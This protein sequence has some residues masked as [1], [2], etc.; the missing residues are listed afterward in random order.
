MFSNFSANPLRGLPNNTASQKRTVFALRNFLNRTGRSYSRNTLPPKYK[1]F[2]VQQFFTR[3]P[4]RFPHKQHLPIKTAR[5]Y[6][7]QFFGKPPEG[8]AK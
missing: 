2:V 8:G 5:F 1:Y 3:K 7:Q 6:V 4:Y